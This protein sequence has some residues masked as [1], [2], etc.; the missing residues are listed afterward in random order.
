MLPMCQVLGQLDAGHTTVSKTGSHPHG[1][2]AL[3]EKQKQKQE[4]KQ[5][6][7]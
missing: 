2:Y 1:A 3:M 5:V 7:I 6:N 4:Q